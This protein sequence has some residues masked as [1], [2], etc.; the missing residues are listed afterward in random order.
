MMVQFGWTWQETYQHVSLL[1]W[2]LNNSI[3]RTRF[4]IIYYVDRLQV[5]PRFIQRLRECNL[6]TVCTPTTV[7]Q[8]VIYNTKQARLRLSEVTSSTQST[9]FTVPCL[10]FVVV[11]FT[12][13][14]V[15]TSFQYL[16]F[17]TLLQGK[18]AN[19]RGSKLTQNMVQ[20]NIK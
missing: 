7:Y 8:V 1:L 20:K 3:I 17:V 18:E 6:F 12:L 19:F 9:W 11:V 13:K 5:V 4:P 10:L 14:S 15:L 16:L 2:F